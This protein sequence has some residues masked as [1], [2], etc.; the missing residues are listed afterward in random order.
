MLIDDIQLVTG[1]VAAVGFNYIVN[2]GFETALAGPWLVEG[3]HAGSVIV[4]NDAM[5]GNR[6]LQL[7]ST[8]NG[9]VNTDSLNQ[10]FSLV[11]LMGETM[12]LSYWYKETEGLDI[13]NTVLQ[14]SN[15]A[16]V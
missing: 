1:T 16:T 9:A 4:S 11:G 3:N 8:G 14:L 6:S 12:T 5:Q 13:L 10:T 7:S 2:P 15:I